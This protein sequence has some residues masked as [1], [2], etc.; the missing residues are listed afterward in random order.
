MPDDMLDDAISTARQAVKSFNPETQ[1]E[2]I[3]R[4]IK[5]HFDEKWGPYWHVIIGRNFGCHCTHE[6]SRYAYFYLDKNAFMVYK[7]GY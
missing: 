1:G 3:A 2:E 5:R 7:I 6:S 4:H